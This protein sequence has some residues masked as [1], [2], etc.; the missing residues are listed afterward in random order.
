MFVQNLIQL[1]KGKLICCSCSLQV[2]L[3]VKAVK[4]K[5]RLILSA[6][7]PEGSVRLLSDLDISMSQVLSW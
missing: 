3:N 6:S 7:C 2:K 1:I 5:R 4:N